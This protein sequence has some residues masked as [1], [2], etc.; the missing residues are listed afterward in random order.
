MKYKESPW[1]LGIFHFRYPRFLQKVELPEPTTDSSNAPHGRFYWGH[2]Y[3]SI[4]GIGSHEFDME[5]RESTIPTRCSVLKFT[6]FLISRP[7]TRWVLST[8]SNVAQHSSTPYKNRDSERAR[9][10]EWWN[11]SQCNVSH[12][13]KFKSSGREVYSRFVPTMRDKSVETLP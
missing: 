12:S 6:L 9:D 1:F 11:S 3:A 8:S 5:L 10:Q 13:L 2:R 7:D 4:L